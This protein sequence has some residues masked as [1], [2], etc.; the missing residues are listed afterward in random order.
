M[1]G[2]ITTPRLDLVP[3][4]LDAFR[5]APDDRVTLTSAIGAEFDSNWPPEHYDQEM[6][7][8]GHEQLLRN[9][10]PRWVVRYVVLREPK[11]L[12]IGMIGAAGRPKDGVAI[13]GYSICPQFHRRG[14]ASE[15]LQHLID[16]IFAQPEIEKIVAFTFPHIVASIGVLEKAGFTF[17]GDGEEA[18]TIRY[19]LRK[20]GF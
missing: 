18:G 5:A 19:E 15:A 12:A 13:V 11:R 20:P 2:I 16:W 7:D 1:S 14:Y 9:V 4:N 17:A 8:Y 10:D 3:G 6:L